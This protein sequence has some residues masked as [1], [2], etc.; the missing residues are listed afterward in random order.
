MIFQKLRVDL[1]EKPITS[2]SK[3]YIERYQTQL[4]K[5]SD[6]LEEKGTFSSSG[7]QKVILLYDNARPLTSKRTQEH[8]LLRLGDCPA[9]GLNLRF[10][11]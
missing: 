6:I 10:G 2:D 3:R 5:L 8:L 11:S 7:R 9:C 4:I 1:I